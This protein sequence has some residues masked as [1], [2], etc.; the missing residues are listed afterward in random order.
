AEKIKITSGDVETY[1]RA[2]KSEYVQGEQAQISHILM[3]DEKA[4]QDILEKLKSGAEFADLAKEYSQDEA[5]RNDGGKVADWFEKGS[6]IPSIG[7]SEDA[8]AAIFSTDVGKVVDRPVKSDKGF[9]I[10]EVRGRKPQRQKSL[11]EVRPEVLRALRSRKEREIREALLAELRQ[12]HDVVIHH[13][14]F[15][16]QQ[17]EQAKQ[18][19]KPKP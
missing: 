4:A 7:Y 8:T 12:R 10:I 3:K 15:T 14:K 16:Q 18:G 1:F 6:Y 5:T 17:E 9:H 2:H 13:G 19:D 11:D